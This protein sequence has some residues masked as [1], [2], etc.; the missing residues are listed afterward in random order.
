[1]YIRFFKS[2]N[3]ARETERLPK[4]DASIG[5]VASTEF[6]AGNRNSGGGNSDAKSLI[7]SAAEGDRRVS[8]TKDSSP[9]SD[10]NKVQT[11]WVS[12][13]LNKLS[14]KHKISFF[15]Q[16]ENSPSSLAP[17]SM[18][19]IVPVLCFLQ[20]LDLFKTPT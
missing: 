8:P 14:N 2:S 15:F 20:K 11:K 9:I 5:L 13:T 1:M 16:V 18:F 6:F 17:M 19:D 7:A 4:D 10:Q 12:A 3:K